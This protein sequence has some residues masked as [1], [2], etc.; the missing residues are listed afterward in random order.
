MRYVQ[1]IPRRG[2]IMKTI[3]RRTIGRAI[4]SH[5][6]I[7]SIRSSVNLTGFL[8]PS[9]VCFEGAAENT[10]EFSDWK[11]FF[12]FKRLSQASPY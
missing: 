2:K 8:A 10:N 6:I 4:K 5:R 7:G 12:R 1:G 11:T 3:G 9:T